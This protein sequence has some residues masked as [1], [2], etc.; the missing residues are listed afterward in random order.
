MWNTILNTKGMKFMCLDIKNF[1]LTAP[2]DR[3]E[4]MKM[5][6]SLFPSWMREQYNLEKHAKNGFVYIELRRAVWGLPQAG[7]L[8]NKLLHKRLLPHGYYECKH[9]PGLWRHLTRPISFTLVVN[10]F[11]VKYVGQ[12]H[13]DHLINA[14]RENKSLPKIGLAICT[15][16]SSC[17]G[18]II[19]APSIYQC[20]DISK[21]SSKNTSI[22][23]PTSHEI[24][25]TLQ[26]QSNTAPCTNPTTTD[27]SPKLSDAEIKEIQCIIG[28]ISYYVRA[29][30]I[31]I[32]MALS[33]IASEQTRGTTNTM[34][35]AK[36]LL[37]YLTMHPDAT[38]RIRAS[39]M[40]LNVHSNASYLSELNAH[41]RACGH[42]FMG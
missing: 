9:T 19:D 25:H 22:K 21:S 29:V 39:D 10:D 30:N 14:S 28:S 15:A 26:R 32:L 31:T 35:K 18:I 7:I 37:D 23:C 27:I 12:E 3:F 16:G 6:L 24:A 42:F 2:L 40:I 11:G 4:Y 1:Y 41:S 33:S 5:P 34:A 38:V 20:G 36:Q 17:F 13:V 8:A